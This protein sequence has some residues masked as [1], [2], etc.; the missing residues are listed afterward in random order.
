MPGSA[1]SAAEALGGEGS[2]RGASHGA[3][4]DASRRLDLVE[5]LTAE[6]VVARLAEAHRDPAVLS[7]GAALAFDGDGTLWRGDVGD[8]FFHTLVAIGRFLP[9]AVEAMRA[10]GLAAGVAGMDPGPD[11]GVAIARRLFEAY[12]DQRLAE[13]LICE[14]AAWICAGWREDDVSQ[15]AREVVL[16]GGLASRRYVEVGVV[17]DW[18]R[19]SGVPA[20]VV[21][22]S[23]RPVVEAA[24]AC[25]GFD[26]EHVLAVTPCFDQGVMLPDV[27]RPIPYGPGKL[28]LLRERTG[29]RVLL[30]AFGDNVFD[31]PMLQAA[32]LAVLVEPKRRLTDHLCAL[33]ERGAGFASP[34]VCLRVASRPVTG[35]GGVPSTS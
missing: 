18:A 13:E 21:S 4:R 32:R 33:G 30:G 23:P 17:L 9:P 26:G 24:A 6:Q 19:S 2:A 10:V 34:P 3:R 22:A 16:R 12:V 29:G 25:L 28:A 11:A 1:N 15:V 7:R 27:A 14:V 8:D 20:F 5:V 35:D 31:L